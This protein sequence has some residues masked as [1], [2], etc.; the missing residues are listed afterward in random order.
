MPMGHKPKSL[1][2]SEGL[3]EVGKGGIIDVGAS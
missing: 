1:G 3:K 2:W